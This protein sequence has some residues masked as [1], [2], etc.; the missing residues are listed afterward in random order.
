MKIS[1]KKSVQTPSFIAFVALSIALLTGCSLRPVRISPGSNLTDEIS[2]QNILLDQAQLSHVDVLAS[3]NYEVAA[4]YQSLAKKQN[5]KGKASDEILETVGYS[6]AFLQLATLE[7]T[8]VNSRLGKITKARGEAIKAGAR[9]LPDQL[10]ELDED[11]KFLSV[12]KVNFSANQIA[13]LQSN[14]L[15]LEREAI[16][17]SRLKKFKKL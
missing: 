14:Y 8:S 6:R 7:A 5:D 1:N 15:A 17:H 3:K 13:S 2:T 12:Q 11:L 10:N 16:I 9:H 4:K